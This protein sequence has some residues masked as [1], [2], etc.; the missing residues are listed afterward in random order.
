M[1]GLQH[2]FSRFRLTTIAGIE[3]QTSSLHRAVAHTLACCLREDSKRRSLSVAPPRPL[4]I[5]LLGVRPAA[6]QPF[7]LVNQPP[8]NRPAL[9]CQS[10]W[11]AS[12]ARR[13]KTRS[14]GAE[15]VEPRIRPPL[16]IVQLRILFSPR[17][18]LV[19]LP[20]LLPST[21]TAA[22]AIALFFALAPQ[23]PA[24]RPAL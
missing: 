23:L 19:T 6:A 16:T 17:P 22:V 1:R 24:N 4:L 10:Q 15:Q 13:L 18:C 5:L 9:S 7:I 2:Q 12:S 14:K 11:A 8:Y 21:T 20:T 3:R